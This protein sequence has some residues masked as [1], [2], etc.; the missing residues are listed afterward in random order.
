MIAKIPSRAFP[1]LRPCPLK[2]SSQN[3]SP[4]LSERTMSFAEVTPEKKSSRRR[5][6][7]KNRNGR[8]GKQVKKR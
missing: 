2:I 7:S 4:P 3:P 1:Y 6:S 8:E 5:E